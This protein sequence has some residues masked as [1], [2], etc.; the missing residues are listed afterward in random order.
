MWDVAQTVSSDSI[1]ARDCIGIGILSVETGRQAVLFRGE[2]LSLSP[3]WHP[4]GD[5]I[6]CISCSD[7]PLLIDARDPFQ[8]SRHPR[9]CYTYARGTDD[10]YVGPDQI[11]YL[12]VWLSWNPDGKRLAYGRGNGVVA[13]EFDFPNGGR[14]EDLWK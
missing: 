1:D 3:V 5:Y 12:N 9:L 14:L 11:E 2:G 8:P 6:A 10:Q 13:F 7:H 4:S